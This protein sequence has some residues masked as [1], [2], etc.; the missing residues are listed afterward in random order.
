MPLRQN[1]YIS[2]MRLFRKQETLT[3]EKVELRQHERKNYGL[4]AEW[5]GDPEIWHLTSWTSSPLE[6]LR[7][8]APL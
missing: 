2:G 3:G 4:Y 7:G 5:Y 6:P 1:G 8:G